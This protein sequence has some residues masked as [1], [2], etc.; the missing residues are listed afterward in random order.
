MMHP[1]EENIIL[2]VR[3]SIVILAKPDSAGVQ[4]RT[5]I[6]EAEC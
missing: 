2:E 1:S 6:D 4:A 5:H 3:I